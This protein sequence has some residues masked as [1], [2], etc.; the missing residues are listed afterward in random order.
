MSEEESTKVV[1]CMTPDDRQDPW[2]CCCF[3]KG[4]DE[5]HELACLLPN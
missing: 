5:L 3:L 4:T 2:A 1:N